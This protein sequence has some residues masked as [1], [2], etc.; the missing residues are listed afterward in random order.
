[1][2]AEVLNDGDR[3]LRFESGIKFLFDSTEVR[4]KYLKGELNSPAAPSSIRHDPFR[5][6]KCFAL[7]VFIVALL[8]LRVIYFA[9]P[10]IFKI[11]VIIYIILA[12]AFIIFLI[13]SRWW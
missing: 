9:I 1:M 8:F 2:S 13:I 10:S 7:V 3:L 12:I 4:T 5:N 11:C 6:Y